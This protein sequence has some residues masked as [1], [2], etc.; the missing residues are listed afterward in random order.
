MTKKRDKKGVKRGCLGASARFAVESACGAEAGN[1]LLAYLKRAGHAG[2][3]SARRLRSSPAT[4]LKGCHRG[5]VRLSAFGETSNQARDHKGTGGHIKVA[6]SLCS[7]PD[8]HAPFCPPWKRAGV[9]CMHGG[10]PRLRPLHGRQVCARAAPWGGALAR[11]RRRCGDGRHRQ[12]SEF[13]C[14]SA[15]IPA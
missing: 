12:I 6:V 5:V 1:R 10:C 7:R 3:V 4:N 15:L 11:R 9:A 14:A 13:P 8:R 2:F